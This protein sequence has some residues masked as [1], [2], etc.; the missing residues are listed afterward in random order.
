MKIGGSDRSRIPEGGEEGVTI[1]LRISS[2]RE[3]IDPVH[4]LSEQI[5]QR[6][7][8]NEDECYW[9]VTAI[10]EGIIN[11]VLHGNRERPDTYVNVEFEVGWDHL[12]ITVTDEGEGFDPENLPDPVS[13]EHLLDNA[14][15]GVYLMRQLMDEV[16]FTFPEG[17]G[18]TLSMVKSLRASRKVGES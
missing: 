18:T 1:H 4:K 10:R 14:G 6:A 16:S 11:A 12:R 9:L 2:R 13:E 17:G 15:R 5:I 3:F 7:G 8:F